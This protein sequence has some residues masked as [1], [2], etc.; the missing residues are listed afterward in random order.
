MKAR[1]RA[2]IMALDEDDEVNPFPQVP[3][4]QTAAEHQQNANH[5]TYERMRADAKLA[6]YNAAMGVAKQQA[7]VAV[8]GASLFADLHTARWVEKEM[9]RKAEQA[10]NQERAQGMQSKGQRLERGRGISQ[11]T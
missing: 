3:N 1:G 11:G 4:P 9:R 2:P 5:A 7:T 8:G 6:K 10:R